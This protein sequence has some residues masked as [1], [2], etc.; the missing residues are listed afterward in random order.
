MLFSLGATSYQYLLKLLEVGKVAASVP[1]HGT[2]IS[3]ASLAG[4]Q[5]TQKFSITAEDSVGQHGI[6][7]K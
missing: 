6:L 5:Q 1:R 7:G 2:H 3:C 4:Q